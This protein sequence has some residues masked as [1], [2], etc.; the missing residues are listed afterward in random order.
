MKKYILLIISILCIYGSKAQKATNSMYHGSEVD[1]ANRTLNT[2]YEVGSL[3]G[4]VNVSSSGAATY[5]IPIDI[6]PGKAGMEPSISVGYNSNAKDGDLGWKWNLNAG[7]AISRG[8]TTYLQEGYVDGGN[9][10]N[11]DKFYLDGNRLVLHSGTYGADNSEYRTQSESFNRIQ[12]KGSGTSAYFKVWNKAGRILYYGNTTGSKINHTLGTLYWYL[13]KIEDYDGNTID[14]NYTDDS[15]GFRLQSINYAG[16][17]I[18][19]VYEIC[20]DKN[21]SYWLGK[22]LYNNTLVSGI[23]V[24]GQGQLLWSYGFKYVLDIHS[25]LNEIV[26]KAADNK[27]YN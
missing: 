24:F 14:Y 15:N 19:M 11:Q 1:G 10:T 5:T 7:S 26:F 16:N 2:S 23:E 22:E 12:L 9:F 25:Q 3:P 18:N 13:A 27:Q 8:P 6:A 21:T 4:S 17:T 20:E